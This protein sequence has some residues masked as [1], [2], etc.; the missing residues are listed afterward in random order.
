VEAAT[1]KFSTSDVR[2]VKVLFQ[3]EGRFG[4]ISDPG[5]CWAPKDIR[6]TVPA[7]IVREYTHAFSAVCPHSGESFSLILPYADTEAMQIF[8][9]EC[10]LYFKEYRIIMVMDRAAWHRSNDIGEYENIR[11]LHQPSYS[12]ELNPVEHL[13]EYIRENYL[14]NCI[15]STLDELELKLESILKNIMECA[16]SIRTLVGFHWAII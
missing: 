2:P 9:K 16:E 15:W 13:W 12:P 6:P 8:L 3:D 11:V 14:K 5:H 10:S 4:R 7:H 1:E